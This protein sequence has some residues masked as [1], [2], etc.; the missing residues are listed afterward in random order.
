M[1]HDFT[2]DA[3]DFNEK[4]DFMQENQHD[5]P[6]NETEQAA[7]VASKVEDSINYKDLYFRLNADF[8]NF[9]KRTEK[10]KLEWATIMQAEILEK[11]APMII[12]FDRALVTAHTT[13]PAEVKSWLDGFDLVFKNLK[14]RMTE[15]GLEEIKTDGEFNP[16]FH[17]ALVQVESVTNA[18]GTIVQELSKGFIFKGRVIKHAQVSVAK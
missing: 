17:E 15:L 8:Q 2:Q 5:A 14:K 1:V 11:V 12:D 13:A 7:E 6:I 9:K 10:E 4:N 3:K 16:K 18:P